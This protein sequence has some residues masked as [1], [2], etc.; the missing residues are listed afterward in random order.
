[1]PGPQDHSASSPPPSRLFSQE[2]HENVL[3]DYAHGQWCTACDWWR[4]NVD[5]LS[6]SDQDQARRLSVVSRKLAF[7]ARQASMDG[8]ALRHISLAFGSLASG[9]PVN[10]AEVLQ[11]HIMDACVVVDELNAH[12]MV[13]V[14]AQRRISGGENGDEASY[15]LTPAPETA[16]A[17]TRPVRRDRVFV[18]RSRVAEVR[19]LT[20]DTMRQRIRRG[21]EEWPPTTNVQPNGRGRPRAGWWMDELQGHHLLNE[22][23]VQQLR[24]DPGH[25]A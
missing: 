18:L 25:L 22:R 7:A 13:E 4:L 11:T 24:H 14:E 23:H 2:E 8:R 17:E 19:G 6:E 21:Q 15:E 3:L 1:M 12:H 9:F 20:E 10:L 16:D 5:C